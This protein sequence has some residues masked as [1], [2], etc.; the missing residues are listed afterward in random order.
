MA[1]THPAYVELGTRLRPTRD[2]A[3]G[4]LERPGASQR[5]ELVHPVE[6]PLGRGQSLL[7]GGRQ[8]SVGGP[9]GRVVR[10]PQQDRRLQ[11]GPRDAG[12]G[13]RR[14]LE[15]SSA[16]EEADSLDGFERELVVDEHGHH[17]T[18]PSLETIG[19]GG[20]ETAQ[21]AARPGVQHTEPAPLLPGELTCRRT[22]DARRE[23]DPPPSRDLV[24]HPL[25]LETQGRQLPA[26]GQPA[27][28][29]EQLVQR[30]HV[31]RV[32][33]E[34]VPPRRSSTARR[35]LKGSCA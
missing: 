25:P 7:N 30:V 2:V 12:R 8:D 26:R 22:D 33:D 4:A 32:G 3:Q 10:R 9:E 35:S 6:E 19:R 16:P 5:L 20:R 15:R 28:R 21:H 29:R 11:P 13:D 18:A 17:G 14:Q 24:A 27:L 31:P 1:A 23:R 34:A